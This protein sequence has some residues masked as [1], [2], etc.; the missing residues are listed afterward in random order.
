MDST[1]TPAIAEQA[2]ARS[3]SRSRDRP[4]TLQL[5]GPDSHHSP[6][7]AANVPTASAAIAPATDRV[8]SA[9]TTPAANRA[10]AVSTWPAANAA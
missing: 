3:A 10:T 2:L 5:A 1:I 7:A 6:A 8:S 4:G 9:V